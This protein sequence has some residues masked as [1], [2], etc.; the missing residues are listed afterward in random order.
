MKQGLSEAA[1]VRASTLVEK[2]AQAAEKAEAKA[3]KQEQDGILAELAKISCRIRDSDPAPKP[4]KKS[5]KN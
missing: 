4:R 3:D 2:S 5:N 1:P